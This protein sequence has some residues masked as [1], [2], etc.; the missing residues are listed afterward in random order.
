[1][2]K[3]FRFIFSFLYARNWYTG[4]L[5]LSRPRVVLFGAMCILIVIILVIAAVLQLPV[6]YQ[7][8][9]TP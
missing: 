6:H 7:V 5:E 1:M 8:A 3:L 2:R 4:E 9:A